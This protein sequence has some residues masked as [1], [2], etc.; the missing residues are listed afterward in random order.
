M[1]GF[2]AVIFAA[3]VIAGLGCGDRP[4]SRVHGRVTYQNKPLAGAIITFFAADGSTYNTDA[5]ADGSYDVSGIPRGSVRISVQVPPPRSR[6]R[7]DPV[8]GKAAVPP[9]VADSSTAAGSVSIPAKY[10]SP[11]SSELAFELT[12]RNFRS[13]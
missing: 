6:P 5:R 8:P 4:R 11:E 1:R 9:P 3:A 7:P 2:V 10:G 13:T 12:A